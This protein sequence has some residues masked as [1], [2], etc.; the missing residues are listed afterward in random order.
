MRFIK[1]SFF[2]QHFFRKYQFPNIRYKESD[3]TPHSISRGCGWKLRSMITARG[4]SNAARRRR[5]FNTKGEIYVLPRYGRAN[6]RFNAR[7]KRELSYTL[8]VISRNS[9]EWL[10]PRAPTL[11]RSLG[12]IGTHR[13]RFHCRNSRAGLRALAIS[14]SGK[15]DERWR[16]RRRG[17][18]W[19]WRKNP[20]YRVA[21]G[22]SFLRG[23]S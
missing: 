6:V 4:R 17:P 16:R 19:P 10:I 22:K 7:L 2:Y 18:V 3:Y 1:V 23:S 21:L 14:L 20:V 11:A 13:W 8:I 9:V 15:M 12:F 5:R